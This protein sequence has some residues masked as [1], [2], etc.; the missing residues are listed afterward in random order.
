MHNF[1]LLFLLSVSFVSASLDPQS[2]FDRPWI[3]ANDPGQFPDDSLDLPTNTPQAL[4]YPTYAY[5]VDNGNAFT[6]SLHGVLIRRPEHFNL[7]YRILLKMYKMHWKPKNKEEDDRLTA[8]MSYFFARTLGSVRK[9]TPR[10]TGLTVGGYRV[11]SLPIRHDG[12]FN[13]DAVVSQ[14]QIP[15]TQVHPG[16]TLIAKYAFP[17]S[18]EIQ[19]G[20]VHV[21][22]QRGWSIVADI[23]DTV[24]DTWVIDYNKMFRRAFLETYQ[25]V[26]GMPQL[27][28]HLNQHLST[29]DT[30]DVAFHYVSGTPYGLLPSLERFFVNQSFPLGPI[31]VAKFRVKDPSTIWRLPQYVEFKI[32]ETH[33]LARDFPYR[34]FIFFGDSGQRDAQAYGDLMR[35]DPTRKRYQCAFIR[36]ITGVDPKK[37]AKLNV[38]EIFVKAFEGVDQRRWFLFRE[39]E[40]LLG[41]DFHSGR[42]RPP[43]I[44]DSDIGGGL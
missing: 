15:T 20:R 37:E 35:E 12:R 9:L 32:D 23:D 30:P 29:P 31:A 3:L 40:E 7:A 6:P 25:P 41:I 44:P 43:H 4:I 19:Y 18:D 13:T 26:R 42:C 28:Q 33:K 22:G 17:T 16:D 34:R 36:L 24:K 14:I 5:P 11:P 2:A 21:Y 38:R 39:P 1:L 27:F 8:R 10:V